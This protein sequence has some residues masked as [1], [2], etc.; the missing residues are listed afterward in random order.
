MT[1][2]FIQSAPGFFVLSS[3]RRTLAESGLDSLEAVIYCQ[4]GQML[5]KVGLAG[6]RH[7]ICFPLADGQTAYLKRYI[8]PPFFVQMKAWIQHRHRA[9]LAEY[10][11]GPSDELARA[12]ILTPQVIAYGGQWTGCVENCSFIITLEIPNGRSLEQKLPNCFETP[13]AP[14]QRQAKNEF[15]YR[16]ADFVR[17][18]H[19]TGY[20]HRD[21]YL[22][23]LFLSDEQT[24][25]LIDL[26]RTFKP[27]IGS[28]YYRIKDIAQLH[29][30]CPAAKISSS[31]RLRFYLA[32]AQMEKLTTQD[33]KIIRQVHAKALRMAQHDR[34]HGRL[35]PFQERQKQI[36]L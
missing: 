6:W 4:K 28:C 21:L 18:F 1:S 34:K 9:F 3:Y 16:L 30:S 23:H 31:D 8:R 2:P 27:R 13:P 22:S 35:C 17:R 20:C 12:K 29:Y 26:H 10:D 15:I 32:Y 11:K 25:Y 33:K 14:K 5:S 19:E 36:G 24:L 7:R